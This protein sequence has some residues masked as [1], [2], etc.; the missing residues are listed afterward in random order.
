MVTGI[1]FELMLSSVRMRWIFILRQSRRG[2]G[3]GKLVVTGIA[4]AIVASFLA[5]FFAGDEILGFEGA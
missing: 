3:F 5:T 2:E 4:G 1:A